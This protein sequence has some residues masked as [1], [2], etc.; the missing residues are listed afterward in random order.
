MGLYS[1]SPFSEI[2]EFAGMVIPLFI[3]CISVILFLTNC[4]TCWILND[5]LNRIFN[6]LRRASM[7]FMFALLIICIPLLSL[8]PIIL[9]V[10]GI[11]ICELTIQ[12]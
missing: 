4:Q 11:V 5:E 2:L 6:I 1:I 7:G 10:I 9:C 12:F 3:T 8:P